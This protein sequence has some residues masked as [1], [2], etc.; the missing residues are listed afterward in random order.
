MG[1]ARNIA[2]FRVIR[3]F[4]RRSVRYGGFQQADH[5][6]QSAIP[7]AAPGRVLSRPSRLAVPLAAASA[8]HGGSAADAA[9]LAQDTFTR[10]IGTRDLAAVQ[11]PRA[12][13]TTVAKGLMINWL[14]RQSLE[15]AY[16]EALAACP[17][18]LAPSPEDRAIVL[19]TLHDVDAM[20]NTLPPRAKRAFLLSQLEGMKYEA[21][22]EQLGVSLTSVKRYMQQAFRVCLG[23]MS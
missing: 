13:L 5:V 12:Y 15:R 20:L 6:R 7:R 9:D 16:L 10:L 4:F 22:A 11:E 3:F 19:Q 17:E 14:Q 1:F 23:A 21:I 18:P 2:T 8:G